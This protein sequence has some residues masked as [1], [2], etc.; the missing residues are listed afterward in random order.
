LL[1]EKAKKLT[2]G[3]QEFQNVSGGRPP[4]PLPSRRGNVNE[5]RERAPREERGREGRTKGGE[6]VYRRACVER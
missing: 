5:G 2:Y 6:K 4:D 3:N 1:T